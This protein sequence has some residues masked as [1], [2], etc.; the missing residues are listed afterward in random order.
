MYLLSIAHILV[1]CNTSIICKTHKSISISQGVRI[2]KNPNE[3]KQRY[4]KISAK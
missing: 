2:C 1:M 3:E 4:I